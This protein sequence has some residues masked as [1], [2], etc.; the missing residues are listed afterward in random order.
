MFSYVVLHQIYVD[1]AMLLAVHNHAVLFKESTLKS[2]VTCQPPD[3]T[4]PQKTQAMLVGTGKIW[5]NCSLVFSKQGCSEILTHMSAK[6]KLLYVG[7]ASF[8]P[9]HL[10]DF[11][12]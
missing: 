5:K 1:T 3:F 10:D 8:F 11:L 6:K 7:A 9:N 12:A 2:Q 4:Q